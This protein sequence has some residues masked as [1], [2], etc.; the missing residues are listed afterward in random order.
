[1][2]VFLTEEK[3]NSLVESCRELL[4]KSQ[5]SV[6][7]GA[8][9]IGKIVSSFPAVKYRPL[10]YRSLEEDKKE[11]LRVSNGD[12]DK[13]MILSSD[14]KAELVWWLHNVYSAYN[15]VGVSDP[16]VVISSDASKIG[17]GC[18]CEGVTA[19][20]QWLPIERQFHISYLELNAAF[21][22]LNCFQS[23]IKGKHVRL[24]CYNMT[25]V[26]CVNHM[27]TSHS[28]S[29]NSLTKDLLEWCIAQKV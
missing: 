2:T 11:A 23:K 24:M 21:F 15:N 14:S 7:Q 3:V 6:R 17:W 29:C 12:Y 9:A 13:P 8:K 16:E 26:A 19:G 4:Q 10:H 22:V 27:G 20:G 25:T 5:P 1:M 18:E 28:P